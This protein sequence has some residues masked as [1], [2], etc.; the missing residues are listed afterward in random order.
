MLYF[1]DLLVLW[2]GPGR[3]LLFHY[4]K[5]TAFVNLSW[6]AECFSIT[7]SSQRTFAK[8]S[9]YIILLAVYDIGVLFHQ[10]TSRKISQR[11]WKLIVRFFLVCKLLIIQRFLGAI[12]P[13]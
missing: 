6:S 4:C 10:L 13:S 7:F 11:P 2:N 1:S 3:F 9:Y 8:Q 5:T 12:K